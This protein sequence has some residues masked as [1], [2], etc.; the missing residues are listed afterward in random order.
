MSQGRVALV[1]D[2]RI[3][4]PA[5]GSIAVYTNESGAD[6]EVAGH[7]MTSFFGQ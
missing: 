3:P 4:T 1:G 2:G 7:S 6:H 5:P